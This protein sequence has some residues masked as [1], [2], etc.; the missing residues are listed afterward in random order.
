M[1]QNLHPQLSQEAI[2]R[3][4]NDAFHDTQQYLKESKFRGRHMEL[5]GPVLK[6]KKEAVLAA[7]PEIRNRYAAKYPN[8]NVDEIWI[9][10]CG[11]MGASM[12][13]LDRLYHLTLAMAL[14]MLDLL[15]THG[16]WPSELLQPFAE[17]EPREEW[18]LP[19]LSDPLFDDSLIFEMVRIIWDRNPRRA[20]ESCLLNLETAKY[21]PSPVPE[22]QMREDRIQFQDLFDRIDS[23]WKERAMTRFREQ[24]EKFLDLMFDCADRYSREAARLNQKVNLAMMRYENDRKNRKLPIQ[25][26]QKSFQSVEAFSAQLQKS[27][28][29]AQT[30]L[31]QNMDSRSRAEEADAMVEAAIHDFQDAPMD[32]EILENRIPQED[33]EKL[34]R[35]EVEDPYETCFGYLCLLESGS[36][37][38]WLSNLSGFVLQLA[39]RKLPWTVYG[40]DSIVDEELLEP[41]E[42]GERFDDTKDESNRIPGQPLDWIRKKARL[43]G[44]DYEDR[45][46][47]EPMK[48]PVPNWKINLPQLVYGFTGTLMPRTVHSFDGTA[49]DLERIGVD[50]GYA[51]G[52]ELYLQLAWDSGIKVHMERKLQEEPLPEIEHPDPDIY[53]QLKNLRTQVQTLKQELHACEQEKKRLGEEIN[54]IAQQEEEER[55]ELAALRELIYLQSNEHQFAENRED[56]MDIVLP[57]HN[58]CRIAVFGGH[59]TWLKM[60]RSLLPD[61]VFI[62]RG[63]TPNETLIR[64]QDKIWIQGNALSHSDFYKIINTT[65]ANH[66]PVRYFGFASAQKCARQLAE[67]DMDNSV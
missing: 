50:S 41:Y 6:R 61:V 51:R 64:G 67:D 23:V 66:I 31:Q 4:I 18:H 15:E 52:I 10:H 22:G 14:H 21:T 47:Y 33:L 57:Y 39:A 19:E 16:D 11:G 36:S 3:R 25:T 60:I 2:K 28:D 40:G 5:K 42:E 43:Y 24:C 1:A 55:Q 37:L 63:Q 44:L 26:E 9:D 20:A 38:A 17:E 34:S 12:Q 27:M 54:R 62:P 29:Q 30:V 35:L 8:L 56:S 45:V 49:R 48:P 65:R 53:R 13:L 32:M 46:L 59:E 58:R 7:L